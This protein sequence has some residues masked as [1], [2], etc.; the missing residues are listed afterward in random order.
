MFLKPQ[1]TL[2][3]LKHWS[4][5]LSQQHLAVRDLAESIGISASEVSKGGKRLL[6][7]R[8]LVERDGV[9]FSEQNA[10]LEWLSYGV[11]YAYPAQQ[12]GYG[13]GMPSAWNCPLVKS[14]ISPPSPAFV[15][16]VPGGEVEGV[17]LEPFYTSVPF[18]STH[19]KALYHVLAL[20]DAVRVGK[21]RELAVARELL[22]NLIIESANEEL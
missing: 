20:V 22:K 10:L 1:D 6:A 12:V 14:D 19:D 2:I 15:W 11:R 3:V 7:A 21:P 13:R 16:S 4:L 17:L 18:A 9:F 8:L 5:R